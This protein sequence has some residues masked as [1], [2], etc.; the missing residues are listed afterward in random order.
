MRTEREKLFWLKPAPGVA[1]FSW[2]CR[3]SPVA[4]ICSHGRWSFADQF[5]QK[6]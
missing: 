5:E 6:Y 2:C 4:S 1:Q 3:Y